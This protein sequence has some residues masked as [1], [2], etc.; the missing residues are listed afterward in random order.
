MRLLDKLKKHLKEKRGEASLLFMFS[1]IFIF[2]IILFMIDL[3]RLTYIQ[4][5]ATSLMREVVDIVSSQ[6]GIDKD[7][8]DQFPKDRITYITNAEVEKLVNNTMLDRGVERGDLSF[9]GAGPGGEDVPINAST[10]IEV[11]YGDDM[12]VRLRYG[13]D[14]LS[15]PTQGDKGYNIVLNIT[16]TTR[17]KYKHRDSETKWEGIT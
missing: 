8:P 5:D 13:F 14:F 2:W 1:M 17:S 4:L 7:A 3:F 15:I 11:D 6:G 12:T 16:R 9:V 10:K